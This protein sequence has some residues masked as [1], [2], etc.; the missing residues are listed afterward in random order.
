MFNNKS[1]EQQQA[2]LLQ[3]KADAQMYNSEIVY[4]NSVIANKSKEVD[5]YRQTNPKLA[6]MLMSQVR[7]A[8]SQLNQIEQEKHSAL[9]SW[10]SNNTILPSTLAIA[11]TY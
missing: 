5:S 4:M 10:M 3:W 2:Y 9:M 8:K 11:L 1:P 7:L 6:V